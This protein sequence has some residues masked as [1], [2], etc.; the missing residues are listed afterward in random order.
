MQQKPLKSEPS[1]FAV[2][3]N[4]RQDAELK[5]GA[6]DRS[7]RRLFKQIFG[8]DRF[9]KNATRL[10]IWTTVEEVLATLTP[11]Q[12]KIVK[13]RFCS[14][15]KNNQESVARHFAISQPGVSHIEAKA[16][17]KLSHPSRSRRLKAF[18]EG[19]Q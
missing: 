9:Q 12:E 6:Y 7:L 19:E 18:L 2:L 16:I 3:E 13:L 1:A 11:R 17:E 5:L 14:T 15:T 4:I 8:H 10:E